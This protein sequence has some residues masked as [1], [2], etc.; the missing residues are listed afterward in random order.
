M[1]AAG[2]IG[3]TALA[4]NVPIFRYALERWEPAEYQAVVFHRGPLSAAEQQA[5][6]SLRGG[7]PD[8]EKAAENL[9]I[10]SFDVSGGLDA[11]TAKLWQEQTNATCPW[12]VVRFPDA[13]PQAPALWSG[14]LLSPEIGPLL[15][16]PLRREIAR[17]LTRGD[18]AVWLLAESDDARQN[19]KVTAL[20]EAEFKALEKKLELPPPL[21][22]DPR[23]RS[24]LPL[25]V[26]F[27]TL[28]LSRK[29]AGEAEFRRIISRN[30]ARLAAEPQ[31]IVFPIFGRGR[32]L[33]ALI[34]TNI[35]ADLI[36][37]VGRFICGVCS[38]EVKEM[39]PGFDLLMAADWDSIF[40]A[41]AEAK[42]AEVLVSPVT[43]PP[44]PPRTPRAFPPA[45]PGSGSEGPLLSRTV[46]WAGAALSAL[47]LVLSGA[48][49]LRGRR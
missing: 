44:L 42:A 25:R 24:E 31:P 46:V 43:L 19:D 16:S 5:V 18:S 49:W 26:A 27:S 22:D 17:R 33:T 7:R 36:G 35:N 38:C 2:A 8:H 45:V 14:P 12:L 1:V 37:E 39:N 41:G 34:G 48:L 15:D 32:V 20:V 9:V 30:D 29:D 11:V 10:E 40:Q 23:M 4:C 6:G 3:S 21:P 13:A 47:L 28:R